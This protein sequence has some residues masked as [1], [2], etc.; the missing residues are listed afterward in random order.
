M[1][2]RSLALLLLVAGSAAAAGPAHAGE[3]CFGAAARDPWKRC[4]NPRLRLA[5]EPT[6]AAARRGLNAPCTVIERIGPVHICESGVS[7]A[8]ASETVALVGD[9]HAAHWRAALETAARAHRWRILSA[10]YGGCPLS[11]AFRA[12]PR[13]VQRAGCVEWK[14]GVFAWFAHHP[15]VHIVFVSGL[16]GATGVV[17]SGGRSEFETSVSGYR[18]A[19][20]ALPASVRRIV[21]IRDNPKMLAATAAC[22][23]R[24]AARRRPP[25]LACAAP[26]RAVMQPDPMAEAA[27]RLHSRR[28]R[29]VDLTRFFCD[30]RRCFPVVGGALTLKDTTHITAVFSRSLGPFLRR[31]VDRVLPG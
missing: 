18:R 6:P 8:E 23:T 19:W 29:S 24:A 20:R 14:R 15:E 3:R 25:G 30:R 9:S 7:R 27:R 22:V 13:P 26:R 4:E 28:V 12:H 2:A 5:V 1:R 17:P 16:T 10:I 31:A 11:A 21:V